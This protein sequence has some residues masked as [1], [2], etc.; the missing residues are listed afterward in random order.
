MTMDPNS[1]EFDKLRALLALKRHEPPPPGYFT[2]FSSKV[3]AR[4]EAE[5]TAREASWWRALLRRW[6]TSPVLTCAYGA[7]VASLLILGINWAAHFDQQTA[8][9]AGGGAGSPVATPMPVDSTMPPAMPQ[10]AGSQRAPLGE[11]GTNPPGGLL[12]SNSPFRLPALPVERAGFP[13]N[14]R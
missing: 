8:G 14:N 11:N 1:N 10:I 6:Q 4:L 13:A 2:S 7:T 5:Q 3:I 12:A 9:G